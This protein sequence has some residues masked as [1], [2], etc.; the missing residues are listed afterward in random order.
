MHRFNE[1]HSPETGRYLDCFCEITSGI[2]VSGQG[3][4]SLTFDMLICF[5]I[6]TAHT[7]THTHT[8][9]QS[10]A[11]GEKLKD[12]AIEMG[13]TPAAITYLQQKVPHKL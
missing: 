5:L 6:S 9:A 12:L 8:H 1:D 11:N 4:L 3:E 13:V 2:G 7:H 10:D